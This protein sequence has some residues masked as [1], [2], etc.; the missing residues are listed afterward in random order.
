MRLRR[1][2]QETQIVEVPAKQDLRRVL[3]RLT[4]PLQPLL[5]MPKDQPQDQSSYQTP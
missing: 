4:L 5:P 3:L 1:V 2:G